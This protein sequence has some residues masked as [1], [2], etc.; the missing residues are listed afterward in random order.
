MTDT[1]FF[2]FLVAVYK[3]FVKACDD[4]IWSGS[5]GLIVSVYIGVYFRSLPQPF[6]QIALVGGLVVGFIWL[7]YSIWV[8]FGGRYEQ[9]ILERAVRKIGENEETTKLP[10]RAARQ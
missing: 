8:N 4:P 9:L 10:S 6:G 1:N 7:V 3:S 5:I 2:E